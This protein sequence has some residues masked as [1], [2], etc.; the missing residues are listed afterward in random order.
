[1]FTFTPPENLPARHVVEALQNLHQGRFAAARGAQQGHGLP[2]P[3]RQADVPENLVPV[4]VV[5]A[6][7]AELDIPVDGVIGGVG[8]VLFSLRFQYFAHRPKETIACPG[9]HE[10]PQL[11]D[12]H[13]T[14]RCS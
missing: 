14:W 1:L 11:P 13:S 8:V 9:G 12:G 4:V 6:H 2:L 7:V 10:A 5:E 3:D